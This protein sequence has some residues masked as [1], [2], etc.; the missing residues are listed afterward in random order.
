MA[1]YPVRNHRNQ[2]LL[3]ILFST[4][5][6]SSLE[7][8]SNRASVLSSPNVASLLA[9]VRTIGHPCLNLILP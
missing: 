6:S 4:A 7:Y 3:S 5:L 9:N 1:W 2:I 8:C